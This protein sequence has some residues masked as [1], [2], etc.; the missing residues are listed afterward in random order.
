MDNHSY[1][2]KT[3]RRSWTRAIVLFVGAFVLGG[4][5]LPNVRVSWREPNSGAETRD[6]LG[7][8]PSNPPAGL[9]TDEIYARAAQTAYKA[10]VNI[11]RT[12]RVQMRPSIFDDDPFTP[13][14]GESSSEG[15]GVIISENGYILTNEHVVGEVNEADR[16]IQVTLTDGRQFSGTVVGADHTTDVALVKINGTSLPVAKMGTVRGLVPGQMVVAIG[17]PL[18]FRFTVTHGVISALGRPISA[19]NN[20]RIYPNLIQHDAGINPGNS[21]GPLVNL[22]GQVIGINTLVD[23]RAQAIGFAIPIDTAL[24]VADELKR[25]GKIKRPWLGIVVDS[26]S[27]FYVQ[28][29][30]LPDVAG[31][32]VQGVYRE[33]PSADAG[34]QRGDVIVRMAGQP[35]RSEEDY[36]NIE[37]KLKI[38]QKIT[39]E[40]QR[41]DQR[42]SGTVTVGEAP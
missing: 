2:T 24:R 8:V 9:A 12:Q 32:V 14:Y 21:G 17:N 30:G 29:F 28:R 34:L 15:S 20:T 18:G 23:P 5:V 27:S 38:G 31:A 40:I 25:Y 33:G 22:Q 4:L 37:Q 16:K 6:G 11:D 7:V 19:E 10:V 3:L 41:G 13:H 26:N 39:I 42:G 36:R 1:N 35:V